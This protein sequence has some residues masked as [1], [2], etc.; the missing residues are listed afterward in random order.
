MVREIER[1]RN[2]EDWGGRG[3][4]RGR[5]IN[6]GGRRELVSDTEAIIARG[7]ECG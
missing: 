1:K 5:P 6:N 7:R 4:G 2:E 3:E